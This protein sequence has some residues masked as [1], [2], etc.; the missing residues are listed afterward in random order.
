MKLVSAGDVWKSMPHIQTSQPG[1]NQTFVV[2]GIADPELD[3][4]AVSFS[5]HD[6]AT[7]K[8]ENPFN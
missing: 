7:R 3:V 6:R 1:N 5:C 8:N 2:C 4:C